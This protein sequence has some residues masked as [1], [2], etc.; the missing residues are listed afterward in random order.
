MPETDSLLGRRA[1]LS[2]A[3]QA[4]PGE[5]MRDTFATEQ[6]V[7]PQH[8]AQGP[9]PLSFDVERQIPAAPQAEFDCLVMCSGGK[10]STYLLYQL[11]RVYNRRVMALTIDTG[12]EAKNFLD[13]AAAVAEKVN[14]PWAIV[15]PP[16]STMTAFYRALISN[17]PALNSE[18]KQ[19][20]VICHICS[21]MMQSIAACFAARYGIP[22]V[23]SGINK[24]Q[25][26]G[27]AQLIND[28]AQFKI[29]LRMYEFR[30]H[31]TYQLWQTLTDYGEN[32]ALRGL[33]DQ[34]YNPPSQVSTVYPFL[35]LSYDI[36]AI[37]NYL[38][39]EIGWRPPNDQ[40]PEEYYA[41][42]CRLF[43][44]FPY[45]K[46]LGLIGD[47]HELEEVR[48]QVERGEL[49]ERYYEA[50]VSALAQFEA[51]TLEQL[52]PTDLLT[53]LGWQADKLEMS[54]TREASD[55]HRRAERSHFERGRAAQE[56]RPPDSVPSSERERGE[57]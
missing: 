13:K 48:S 45:L 49:D 32:P 16:K 4:L 55:G 26:G 20:N 44:M 46:R 37:I 30:H 39:S 40:K 6:P 33:I 9:A 47:I 36:R 1:R 22:V 43:R 41:S 25:F 10:D 51:Q 23:V 57:I 34:A 52:R 53:E 35:F 2:S 19:V 31:Q 21:Y 38:V 56:S 14:V 15:K 50:A 12:F 5:A 7:I 17:A 18:S 29:A 8:P 3:N 28:E 24:D 27:L 54:R 42:G 11:H